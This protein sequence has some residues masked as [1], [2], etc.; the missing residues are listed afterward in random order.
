MTCLTERQWFLLWCTLYYSYQRFGIMNVLNIS[1]HFLVKQFQE[2]LTS[3]W[4]LVLFC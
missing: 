3:E 4:I 2:V 1:E